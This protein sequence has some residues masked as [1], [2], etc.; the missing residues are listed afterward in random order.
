MQK[1]ILLLWFPKLAY[2]RNNEEITK[3]LT[4]Q[5]WRKIDILGFLNF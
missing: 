4:N 2:E 3:S 5:Y 1:V